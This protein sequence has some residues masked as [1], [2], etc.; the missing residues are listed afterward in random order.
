MSA[1]SINIRFT[2]RAAPYVGNQALTFSCQALAV[3]SP[4]PGDKLRIDSIPNCP[5]FVVQERYWTLGA[6]TT[7]TIWLDEPQD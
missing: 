3:Q 5:W 4:I 2:Q 7:L 6:A 1:L